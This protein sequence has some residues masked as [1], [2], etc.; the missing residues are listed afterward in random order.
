LTRHPVAGLATTGQHR[1]QMVGDGL[2]HASGSRHQ[3]Q[4][5]R[6][7]R[8]P[9]TAAPA[10]RQQPCRPSAAGLCWFRTCRQYSTGPVPSAASS[11]L[12]TMAGPAWAAV[13][14]PQRDHAASQQQ[15]SATTARWPSPYRAH[16]CRGCCRRPSQVPLISAQARSTAGWQPVPGGG[17]GIRAMRITM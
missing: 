4:Q 16:R 3:L 2:R 12:S 13:C 8:T 1:M 15:V 14:W 5:Q 10:G 17:I 11:R 7:P 6:A 9:A